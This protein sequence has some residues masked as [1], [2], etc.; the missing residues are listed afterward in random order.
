MIK[1]NHV[2]QLVLSVLITLLL[3]ACGGGDSCPQ[4]D[5][6]TTSTTS[7]LTTNIGTIVDAPVSNITYHCGTTIAKTDTQGRFACSEFP[8]VFTVGEIEVGSISAMTDDWVIY[9]QDLVGVG[10]DDF[11]NEEVLK[12]AIFLQSLDDDG[13]MSTT[14]HIPN[15]LVLGGDLNLDDLS[16]EETRQLLLDNGVDPVSED[17]AREHLREHA[18]TE[19]VVGE[20]IEGE[21]EEVAG[22]P[23]KPILLTTLASVTNRDE[24]NIEIQGLANS[25][26]FIDGVAHGTTD[27]NGKAELNLVLDS[28]DGENSFAITLK[29]SNGGESEALIVKIL[30][31]TVAPDMPSLETSLTGTENSQ[32]TLSISGENQTTVYI[33]GLSSSRVISNGKTTIVV[34]LS[35]GSNQFSITLKDKAKNVSEAL[36][37]TITRTAPPPMTDAE[38]VSLAKSSLDLGDTSAISSNM[39][40]PTTGLYGTTI[41]YSSSNTALL[42]NTG[43]VTN[44]EDEITV[45]LTATITKGSSSST[46]IFSV[47]VIPELP[48]F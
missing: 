9:P 23:S 44:P 21:G 41:T 14:I 24:F 37:F 47:T 36:T 39:A 26:I 46:K 35:I 10:R 48:T 30:K 40:L 3:T 20:T 6:S 45:T 38:A 42:S 1:S 13:D 15:T 28:D 7:P 5:E 29:N 27:N 34:G 18:S 25:R 31:D 22:L 33:N 17:A 11:N 2:V 4:T 19:G 12:I 43:V 32:Y 8:V 16:L